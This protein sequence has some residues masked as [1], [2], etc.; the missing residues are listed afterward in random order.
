MQSTDMH[1]FEAA[2]E[3]HGRSS[4]PE[5]VIIGLYGIPGSG[6][7]FQLEVLKRGLDKTRFD[8]YDGSQVIGDVTPGG[9]EAFHGSSEKSKCEFRERAI[10]RIHERACESGKAAIVAGHGMLWSEGEVVG[11]W[12]CTP[13]DLQFYTH[14]LYLNVPPETIAGYRRQDRAKRRPDVSIAHLVKW[15]NAEIEKLRQ[16]CRI[17]NIL[18]SSFSPSLDASRKLISL[19]EDFHRHSED[20]NTRLAKNQVDEILGVGPQIPETVLLFDA[21]KTLAPQDSGTLFWSELPQ[22]TSGEGATCPLKDLFAGPLQYSYRSFRQATLLCEEAVC[23]GQYAQHCKKVAG[24]IEMHQ[25]LVYILRLI[26]GHP[27]IR[28]IVL[29]CGIRGIWEMV[30][31][32]ENLGT[33]VSVIGGGRLSDA[34]VMT[35]DLKEELV[36]HIRNTHGSYV[37][38]FGDSPLDLDMLRAAHQAVVVTGEESSRSHSMDN[39]L[40]TLLEAD[41]FHPRQMVLPAHATPRLDLSRLPLIQL[42]EQF[43]MDEIFIC[44]N[45]LHIVDA[46]HHPTAK[47]L[48]TPMRD[49]AVSGPA[50]RGAH[51]R[52][53]WYLATEYCT[54]IMGVETFTIR[55]VQGHPTVGH[56]ILHENETLIVALMR[57]GEPMALG[58]SEALPTASFHHAQEPRDISPKYLVNVKTVVLV[59]SVVNSGKSIL[60]FVRHIRTCQ[61]TVRILVVAGVIQSQSVTTSSIAQEFRR[62]RH[63]S[64]IALRLSEN[65]FTGSGGTDTGN[66]LFNTTNL[67]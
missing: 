21:D 40:A 61:A 58:V 28:A 33:G 65:K 17:H 47:I 6:K 63:L 25:Q 67:A 9:L 16:I 52:V 46:T 45:Q 36:K 29:T 42:S 41:G 44:W 50:L 56:R 48:M 5:A 23:D 3:A 32:R 38:A 54:G 49:A 51:H 10:S 22:S 57:G 13:A 66:R 43:I 24:M 34:I 31:Q 59:D 37:W 64:F 19:L 8:F 30:L 4:R 53:G 14:I 1:T 20:L 35:P 11:Q 62:F 55:H 60:E 39:E 18:F 27:H 15:Q 26:E 7:S 12:V 2:N